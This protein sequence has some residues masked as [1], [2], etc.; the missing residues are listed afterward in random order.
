MSVAYK[1]VTY[2]APLK[3]LIDVRGLI[4]QFFEAVCYAKSP[5]ERAQNFL[6]LWK[7]S[8]HCSDCVTL[9]CQN[10]FRLRRLIY[11]IAEMCNPEDADEKEASKEDI[12]SKLNELLPFMKVPEKP[13]FNV[14]ARVPN[15][16]SMCM[17]YGFM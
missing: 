10:K 13:E 14:E 7:R 16:I 6:A 11:E 3:K 4:E 1:K 15:L 8:K 2:D 9:Y 12:R 17:L 5:I